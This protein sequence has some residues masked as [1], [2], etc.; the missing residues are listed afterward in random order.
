M[1]RSNSGILPFTRDG[2]SSCEGAL[3]G[4]AAG[5]VGSGLHNHVMVDTDGPVCNRVTASYERCCAL[6]LSPINIWNPSWLA[7]RVVFCSASEERSSSPGAWRSPCGRAPSPPLPTNR[8]QRPYVPVVAFELSCFGCCCR[9][10]RSRRPALRWSG[11][12]RT[13][14]RS[15][16]APRCNR[17]KRWS[18]WPA[19]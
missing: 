9:R 19:W 8:Y 10:K 5:N 18:N 14:S 3:A 1:M 12:A 2:L 11:Y 16:P 15:S 6:L 13:A 4:V 17:P 7:R